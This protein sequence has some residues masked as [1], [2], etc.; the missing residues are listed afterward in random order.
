MSVIFVTRV[1]APEPLLANHLV[2]E[3]TP[4]LSSHFQVS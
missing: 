3:A 1:S 4:I 2:L